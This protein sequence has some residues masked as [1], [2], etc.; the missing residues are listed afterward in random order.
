MKY[1]LLIVGQNYKTKLSREWQLVTLVDKREGL[2]AGKEDRNKEV[3]VRTGSRNLVYRR[4]GE[5]RKP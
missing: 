1:D 3:I 5:L 4:P 2:N